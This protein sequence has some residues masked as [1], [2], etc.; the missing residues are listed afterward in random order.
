MSCK[1]QEQFTLSTYSWPVLHIQTVCSFTA[2]PKVNWQFIVWKVMV[3]LPSS[4]IYSSHIGINWIFTPCL[5]PDLLFYNHR[6]LSTL[7]ILAMG[8]SRKYPYPPTDGFHIL[9]PPPPHAFRIPN[10]LTPPPIPFGISAFS[11][12]PLELPVWLNTTPPWSN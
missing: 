8:N 6:T 9:T 10:A 7:L 5:A 4:P 1:K 12:S 3:W 2:V 11:S